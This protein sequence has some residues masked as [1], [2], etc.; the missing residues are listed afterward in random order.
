MH[1]F[2]KHV[3]MRLEYYW[4]FQELNWQYIGISA[5]NDVE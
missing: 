2:E 5:N 4:I 3:C 1:S